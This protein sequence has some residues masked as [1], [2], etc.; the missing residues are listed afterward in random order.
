[1]HL[2]QQPAARVQHTANIV[3]A[4][5]SGVAQYAISKERPRGAPEILGLVKLGGGEFIKRGDA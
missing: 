3:R 4:G 5:T 1:M 2:R